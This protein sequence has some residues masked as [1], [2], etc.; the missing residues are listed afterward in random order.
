MTVIAATDSDFVFE[1]LPKVGED[2][3]AHAAALP[4]QESPAT[5]VPAASGVALRNPLGPLSQL[6]GTW[7][8]RGF[9]T[10]W[11]PHFPAS[12]QDRFLELNLTTETLV[13]TPIN[14]AIP[15]RGLVNPDIN[16]FGLT[17]MQQI[18][19][20]SNGAGLHIEPGIWATVPAS[21]NPKEPATVVRMGSIPHGTVILA[22][23]TSLVV[24]SGPQIQDDNI[25]PFPVNSPP[26]PNSAF[27][28]AEQTFKELNLAIATPF[29]F[30]SPGV[31]QAM[32]KNPNSVLKAAIQGQT[33]TS[34]T[35]L[36][37]S[38]KHTPVQGGGTANTAFLGA[39]ANP[40]GGNA[41]AVEVDA[42]FWIETVKGASGKP[43]FLQLQYTQLVQ[44]DFNGLRWPHVT[45][46][47]LRKH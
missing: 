38:T 40:P 8:G 47:T 5:A 46:A 11:R 26:P 32:V 7:S 9:N 20:A 36:I 43:D 23:G 19:E 28:Q 27:A 25:I 12:P 42:I 15:N 21:A 3:V 16:M 4:T 33:I 29:R 18:A 24:A 10:I 13:F 2:K 35:V 37:I 22:Q 44:L 14:G 41:N 39:A 17:Y 34:T 45:V 30:L 31:T 6:A 1:G